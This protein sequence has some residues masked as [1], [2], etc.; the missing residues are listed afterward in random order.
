[1]GYVPKDEGGK[2]QVKRGWGGEPCKGNFGMLHQG[3][4]FSEGCVL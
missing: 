3:R 4:V 1:M 2:E